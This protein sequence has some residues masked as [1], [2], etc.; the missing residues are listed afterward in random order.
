MLLSCISK[1]GPKPD[2]EKDE[3]SSVTLIIPLH[4]SG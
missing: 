3:V 4:E 2:P 1:I